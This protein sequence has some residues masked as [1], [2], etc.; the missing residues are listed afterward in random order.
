[1]SAEEGERAR[2]PSQ[3]AMS[4]LLDD[5]SDF[6]AP[7]QA[8]IKPMQ[9]DAQ[10]TNAM[11]IE[12]EDDTAADGSRAQRA[13]AAGE[14][15]AKVTLNDCLACSG[16]VTSAET[17]LIGQQS[18]TEFLSHIPAARAVVVSISQAA[19]ASLAVHYSLSSLRLFRALRV[20]FGMLGCEYVIDLG[21]A[22]DI[23]LVESAA[24]FI[25][26]YRAA[27]GRKRAP[28][29][30]VASA[31]AAGT[32][33]AAA[34]RLA[35]AS[36]SAAA[37]GTVA[38]EPCL[39]VIS[40][41]C[42]GWICY[43]EKVHGKLLP[44][45]SAV[46]SAQQIMGTLVRR[47]AEAGPRAPVA[48]AGGVY[49][50]AVMPCFDKK[51]EA[52]RPDFA[53]PQ[54][55]PGQAADAGG[56]RDVDCVLSTAEL[57]ELFAQRQIDIAAIAAALPATEGSAGGSGDGRTAIE[58]GTG[59]SLGRAEG[60]GGLCGVAW[61]GSGSDGVASA[62][63]RSAACAPPAPLSAGGGAGGG[64][65]GQAD[66]DLAALRELAVA[67][68]NVDLASA[69]FRAPPGGS[70]GYA[71]FIFRTAA[72][73]LFGV[74]FAPEAQMAWEPVRGNADLRELKLELHGEVVLRFAAAHGFR[75]VQNVVQKL[76]KG[77]CS[78]DYV[79]FMACPS[80]CLN[81]GG[82]VRPA[83]G[84]GESGK[85]RLARVR[86]AHHASGGEARLGWPAPADD[87]RL[88]ALYA[89]GGLLEGGPMSA[90]SQ[91][92]L[93]TQYH[94]REKFQSGLSIQW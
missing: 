56:R 79:E 14:A 17:V 23:S 57:V 54:G 18:V 74:H 35:A 16:C 37:E 5:L 20:A 44:H 36:G 80:G 24:E 62:S 67:A 90:A 88:R 83:V 40:S 28:A 63:G 41:S 58:G 12:L 93:H 32:A 39:P 86:E 82:Q 19:R 21:L 52:S 13:P 70:G 85:Q 7:S 65:V 84:S 4:V 72:A 78:Y 92:H 50:C 87:T 71:E 2:R 33:G 6:I 10:R 45:V 29:G 69:S 59:G 46:K 3:G 30:A 34:G 64:R 1:M 42:P 55:P 76:S 89:P 31:G 22:S 11:R 81:G 27:G 91:L 51:L 68:N 48:A 9:I 49:H 26:R 75:N 94:A 25:H 8:C 73:E 66:S 60:G 15:V 53:D 61:E 47:L 43:V 77:R 38:A